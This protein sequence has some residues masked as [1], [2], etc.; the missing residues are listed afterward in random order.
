MKRPAS[1]LFPSYPPLAA[2]AIVMHGWAW[3]ILLLAYFLPRLC[4][5][6]L[7]GFEGL[8]WFDQTSTR[9]DE[10]LLLCSLKNDV[11][12]FFSCFPSCLCLRCPCDRG[13]EELRLLGEGLRGVLDGGVG[14]GEGGGAGRLFPAG[15][16]AEKS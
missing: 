15:L 16:E 9:A 10:T 11:F 3:I 7:V 14:G 12:F 8:E 1:L 6:F 4:V 5:L 13:A 2:K